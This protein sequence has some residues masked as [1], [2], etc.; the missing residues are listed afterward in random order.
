MRAACFYVASA[1]RDMH[2]TY[3]HNGMLRLRIIW[4]MSFAIH[5]KCDLVQENK[6]NDNEFL[7]I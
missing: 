6:E 5:K 1:K 2:T 3:K 7:R 4:R